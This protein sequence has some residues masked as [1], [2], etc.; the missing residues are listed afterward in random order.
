[1]NLFPDKKVCKE[2]DC[3]IYNNWDCD[4]R[5]TS[6]SKLSCGHLDYENP[7]DRCCFLCDYFCTEGC[8]WEA[9]KKENPLKVLMQ[10]R[11]VQNAVKSH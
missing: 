6:C 7:R 8:G 10:Q 11:V 5:A 2:I 3:W 1:M 9:F 4:F